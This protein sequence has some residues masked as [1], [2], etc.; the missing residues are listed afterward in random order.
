MSETLAELGPGAGS[1]N[2]A[3]KLA[4]RGLRGGIGAGLQNDSPHFGED[5]VQLLKFHGSYQQDDRDQRRAR[6]DSEAGKAYQFMVRARIPGGV[7][8]SAQYLA[9]DRLASE[10]GNGSL[11][12]TTRQGIQLH[13]VVKGDLQRTI[14][15]INDAML[16]TLAACGDVNRNVMACPAPA[17]NAAYAQIAG[18]ANAIA[19]R[20]APR[21]RAYHEL[22]LDGER[23]EAPE[24]EPVYGPTYLPRKF[25]IAVASP[26][27]NCVD[28]FTQDL[29]FVA[30]V[31]GERLE[32][33]TVVAGGGMGA[34]HGKAETFPRL[35]TPLCFAKPDE[36]LDVAE[37]VVTA[38]RDFGDRRNRKH[39]RLKY[40]VEELGIAWLRQ[41]VSKR[42]SFWP[43]D[44]RPVRFD[45]SDDH[46]GWHRDAGGAWY[47]GLCVG[48]GRVSDREGS[49]LRS[50]LRE[51]AAR[52][53]V[54]FRITGQQNVLLTGIAGAQ[55]SAFDAALRRFGIDAD[56]GTL[57]IARYAMACPALPTC[58]LAVA[59][60]ERALP[61]VLEL[62][63][64]E[65]A[66]LGL[67]D[68][69]VAV[70]MTGCPNGCARPRMADIGIVGRSSD[71]YD[72][73]VG[74]NAANT[75]LNLL[76]AKGVKRT[77][78]AAV[79][80]P[81]L[82][83][84]RAERHPAESFGDFAARLPLARS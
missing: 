74:G 52:F 50:A 56:P 44:P 30:H 71:L 64:S 53:E 57:G 31:A 11:R 62:L 46:L 36:V 17:P 34:T 6:R 5:D 22:W 1:A 54:G 49:P 70:R 43:D 47:F 75:R 32:G 33:F 39:A 23:V 24:I 59:E 68:E 82:E 77:E 80:R 69:V 38:Y 42:I 3:I 41:E 81:A 19:E 12:F 66:A 14:R 63:E 2:E 37:A 78:I 16:S 73:F 28:V 67:Q 76:F 21:T 79:L 15:G 84:W 60:A 40:V 27:D 29:G 9:I 8:T 4:S 35:A 61:G 55:R 26:G 18:F 83:R 45:R 58:G 51:L 7:L 20:L 72:L 13:G 10:Y 48:N 65:L 25:K